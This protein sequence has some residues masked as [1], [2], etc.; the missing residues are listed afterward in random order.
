MLFVF[1]LK[2]NAQNFTL[3]SQNFEQV[4]KSAV[5]IGD[6]DNDGDVDLFLSG[7]VDNFTSVT[8]LYINQN[9]VFEKS[10][11]EFQGVYLGHLLLGDINQN[12]YLDLIVVGNSNN[13]PI[14]KR[15]N[16][17]N[18]IFTEVTTNIIPFGEYSYG[19]L[20]DFDVDGDL[21]L[22]ICGNEQSAIYKNEEGV[23]QHTDIE[24]KGLNYSACKWVD[25][26][27]NGTLDIVATGEYSALPNTLFY[28]NEEQTFV[29]DEIY[30]QHV[31]N[32]DLAWRDFDADGDPDLAITGYDEN[33]NGISYIYRNDNNGHFKKFS[34]SILG[35]SKSDVDWGDVLNNGTPE[36]LITGS[37]DAC[38][39][40]MTDIYKKE[41]G[42][43]TNI[44]IGFHKVEY[45]DIRFSDYD[46]DGDLDVF[47]TGLDY[48][49]N[50]FSGLYRNEGLSNTY[51]ENEKPSTPTQLQEEIEY[52][53]VILSW[54]ASSDDIT[55]EPSINY[56]VFV[57]K[58]D[59]KEGSGLDDTVF[60]LNMPTSGNAGTTTQYKLLGL[61]KGTYVWTVQAIDDQYQTSDLVA[62]KTFTITDVVSNQDLA[63]NQVQ[64]YPNP[65]TYQ[66]NIDLNQLQP[67][68][69]VI[70][71]VY[72]KTLV[73][74]NSPNADMTVDFS[75][76]ASGIYFVNFIKGDAT[77]LVKKVVK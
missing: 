66:L 34:S 56:N 54:A 76:Y 30:V 5:A 36:L 44:N 49:G 60:S 25:Y 41:N 73:E 35:V 55:P 2:T 19:D 40:L 71:D 53:N 11:Q 75:G 57:K 22:L 77:V 29:E 9:G 68:K 61:E 52:N 24:I 13:T 72:G 23:F 10:D 63:L 8:Y 16:N 26:D 50:G 28:K 58:G 20:G 65:V 43:F 45:G 4:F 62:W 38:G 39:V 67:N 15:Y 27:N 21:D 69:V 33:L 74:M 48:T 70:T 47:I 46:N 18:G 32:G 64:V 14:A 1:H 12:G 17:Q 3:Q 37:C 31:M 42:F 59:Y 6:I 51:T 7:L